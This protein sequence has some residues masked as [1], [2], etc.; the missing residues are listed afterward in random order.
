MDTL[1]IICKGI[2]EK[3]GF[4]REHTGRGEDISPEFVIGNLSPDAK[5]LM[6]TLED[7]F[8]PIKNFTHWVIWNIPAASVIPK[9]IPHGKQTLGSASQG[10][11]YGFHRYA[12]P[13]PPRGKTHMYCFTVYALDC[14]LDLNALCFKRKVLRAA[15][16]HVIQHGEV[17]GYFEGNGLRWAK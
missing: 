1:E 10:I 8:H 4:L 9:G 12:G 7:V 17:R 14:S 3:K 6:I 5:T 2:D 11:G 15:K 13:K 16:G